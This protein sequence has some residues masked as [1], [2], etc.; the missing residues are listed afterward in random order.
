[1]T[2]KWYVTWGVGV[3][4]F[5]VSAET[6][7]TNEKRSHLSLMKHIYDNER[8]FEI[9]LHFGVTLDLVGAQPPISILSHNSP[10]FFFPFVPHRSSEQGSLFVSAIEK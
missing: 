7:T 9:L 8:G 2:P 6:V 10:P 4:T 5:N 1:M 3:Q